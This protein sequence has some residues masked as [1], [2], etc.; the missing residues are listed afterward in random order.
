MATLRLHCLAVV[1]ILQVAESYSAI[2]VKLAEKFLAD[3]H[4][5]LE[6]VRTFPEMQSKILGS[7]FWI[8]M[9]KFPCLLIDRRQAVDI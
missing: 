4:Q 7:Y 6:H 3:L 9:R 8:R 2:S 5:R 1:E